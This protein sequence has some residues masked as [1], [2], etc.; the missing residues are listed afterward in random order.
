MGLFCGHSK[1]VPWFAEL[2]S[3]LDTSAFG[4]ICVT[5]NNAASPWL[6]F[7][8]GVIYKTLD[9]RV[10][11]LLFD[12]SPDKL[13][14]PMAQLQATVF[15]SSDLLRLVYTINRESGEAAVPEPKIE[16]TWK[17]SWPSL[18]TQIHSIDKSSD[19]YAPLPASD[20][21]SQAN[22]NEGITDDEVAILQTL[23][24]NHDQESHP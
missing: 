5:R 23:A 2:L 1:G 18:N 19:D 3:Q 7:E 9:A 13:T 21:I 17:H 12:I 24:K 10:A 14:G 4:I 22:T 11:P 6:N 16:K 20:R 8:A 15:D